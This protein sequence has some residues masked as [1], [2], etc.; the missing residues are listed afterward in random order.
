MRESKAVGTLIVTMW[1]SSYFWPLLCN[2]GMHP[3]SFFKHWLCLPKRPDLIVAGRAKNKLFGTKAFKSPCLA[4]RIDFLQPERLSPVG[5]CTSHLGHCSGCQPQRVFQVCIFQIS[6]GFSICYSPYSGGGFILHCPVHW[7]ELFYFQ[8]F[9][10]FLP[11]PVAYV[12]C[13]MYPRLC[14]PVDSAKIDYSCALQWLA[15]CI[16]IPWWCGSVV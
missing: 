11:P 12:M 5:F 4:L 14:G 13:Y 2:D 3:N 6:W 1:K 16:C 7:V 9:S 10:L 8:S 15:C